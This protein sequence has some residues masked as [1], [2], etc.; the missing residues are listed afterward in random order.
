MTFDVVTLFPGMF[1]AAFEGGMLARARRRGRLTVRIHDLR[2]FGVGPHR[3]V[4]D[5]PCGGGGGMVMRPEPFFEC[6][7]W[8]RGQYPAKNELVLLLSPQGRKLDPGFARELAGLD[9]L[10][11]L[12][13][14]YEGVDERVREGLA[15]GEL[16]VG[17]VVLTG[18][19]VP[20]LMVIDAV[21]RFVPGVLGRDGTAEQDTFSNG[22]LEH[23]QYTKPAS[24]R[25]L[26]VPDVLLSGDHGAIERWRE[27][28]SHEATQQKR[29]DLLLGD[30]PES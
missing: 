19:E 6:V 27:R 23:P 30:D 14:R 4:D 21:S 11:L 5:T 3:Q 20:A 10:V 16:S 26:R 1:Q 25:G 22:L 2:R 13:G 28:R 8:I 24:Y 17:D 9:R 29:P 15:D 18:G 7:D 12:S